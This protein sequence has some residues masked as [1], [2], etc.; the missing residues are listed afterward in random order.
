MTEMGRL[1]WAFGLATAQV[2]DL[3]GGGLVSLSF[4]RESISWE[5]IA[6]ES[7]GMEELLIANWP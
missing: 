5:S 1:L 7:S 2:L 6:T 3:T 4:S